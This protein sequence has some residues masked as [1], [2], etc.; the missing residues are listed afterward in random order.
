ME[1]SS[2]EYSDL[3]KILEEELET[4]MGCTEPIALAFTAAKC[5]EVLGTMPDR[6]D[7]YAS[8]SI[9]KNVKSVIVPNTGGLHGMEAATGAGILYGVSD[10]KLEVI[11]EANEKNFAELKE[12][13]NKHIIK[14][15]H[16]ADCCI[17]DIKVVCYKGSDSATV[18]VSNNHTSVT[19]IEKNG[20][21]LYHEDVV[22]N[23]DAGL[24]DRRF[25]SIEKIVDFANTC[26]LNDVKDLLKHQIECNTA[27]AEEGLKNDWGSNIGRTYINTYGNDIRVRAA[28]MAAAGS[29]ARMNGCSMPVVI[30]SGSGN[31]G[32][33]ASLPVVEWAKELK[34]SEEKLLRALI[35]SDLITIHIKTGIGRLSAFCGA[36]IAGSGAGAGIAYL[37][38]ANVEGIGKTI[39]NA[40]GTT[41]GII[42]DGAKSSCA[43]KIKAAVDAG[44][45][46]YEMYLA[47][48]DYCQEDGILG[49]DPERT[50][51]NV[52]QLGAKGMR[53]TN[54][55]IIKIMLGDHMAFVS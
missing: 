24:T 13:L 18:R 33:T 37:R 36:I 10:K 26:D 29:D 27:I 4:A 51:K 12:L 19:H 32:I 48:K 2:K 35:V 46:G 25:M 20:E 45:L 43:G 23:P 14:I 28:A 22:D 49:N 31:Q 50:I 53:S 55:E 3:V 1:K 41:S 44:T 15:F 7:V 47:K 40:L 54:G 34:V 38:G 16:F 42:C 21:V 11:S 30:V 17:L 39:Q 9:I 52:G 8:G 6:V 5:R